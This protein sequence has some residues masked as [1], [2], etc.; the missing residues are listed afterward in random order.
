MRF[1]GQSKTPVL[2]IAAALFPA[3]GCGGTAGTPYMPLAVGNTWQYRLECQPVPNDGKLTLSIERRDDRGFLMP[4]PGGGLSWW[5]VEEGFLVLERPGEIITFF[6]IPPSTGVSWW[7]K[8]ADGQRYCMRVAGFEDVEVPAGRFENALRIEM[9]NESCTKRAVFHFGKG[10]GLV[11]RVS[12]KEGGTV[13]IEL[14]E[15]R[16]VPTPNSTRVE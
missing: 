14:L 13:S 1:I 16:P 8:G 3:A 5:R 12:A 2:I 15:F 10:T 7:I 11:K 6:E 4:E 9:E